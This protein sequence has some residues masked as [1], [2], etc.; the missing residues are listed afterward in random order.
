MFADI[1]KILTLVGQLK[2]KLPEMQARLA[3]SRFTGEAGGG[4]VK[5]VVSGK[6]HLV[7]LQ[8]DPRAVCAAGAAGDARELSEMIRSAVAAAQEK[9]AAAAAESLKELTGGMDIPGLSGVLP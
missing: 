5:A 2:T 9:A 8:L 6:M 1:G 7:D 4:A 3:A